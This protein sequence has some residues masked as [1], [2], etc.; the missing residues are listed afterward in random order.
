M[1]CPETNQPIVFL[2]VKKFKKRVLPWSLT[3]SGILVFY[4][5]Q[6]VSKKVPKKWSNSPL[7]RHLF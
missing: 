7:K 2:V 3:E 4:F 5:L 6:K 1:N